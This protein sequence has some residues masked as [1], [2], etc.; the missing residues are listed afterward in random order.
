MSRAQFA[1]LRQRHH[2]AR[3]LAEACLA[4]LPPRGRRGRQGRFVNP[5]TKTEAAD[6]MRMKE[7][8]FDAMMSKALGVPAPLG[9]VANDKPKRLSAYPKKPKS[10]G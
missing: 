1:A 9:E 6:E 3:A 7:S 5:K 10:E 2:A 8:D 4:A